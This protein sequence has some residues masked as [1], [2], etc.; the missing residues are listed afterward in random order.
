LPKLK[1]A[2]I[3]KLIHQNAEIISRKLGSYGNWRAKR[4][5]RAESVGK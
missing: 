1:K 5:F 4:E 2:Q 3:N